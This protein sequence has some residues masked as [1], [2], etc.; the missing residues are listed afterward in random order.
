VLGGVAGGVLGSQIGHGHGRTASII[1][2]TII[3]AVVGKEIGRSVDRT[4]ELKA[5]QTLETNK[6]GR[7]STWV[8]PDTHSEVTVTPTRTYQLAKNDYCREYTT[9][10]SVGGERQSA[11]GTACRQPDGSWKVVN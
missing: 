3:G 10:V 8:N 1:A 7:S 9:E 5:Q 11:Y 4:D 2:G 6:T